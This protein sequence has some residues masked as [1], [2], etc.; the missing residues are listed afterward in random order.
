MKEYV[1]FRIPEKYAER[2]LSPDQGQ[3]LGDSVRKLTVAT[4][5]PLYE[6]IRIIEE[7]Q[8]KRGE[9]F[10][11]GWEI[12]HRYS[13]EELTAAQ[14][15][16]LAITAV[17]EP[18]GEECGTIYDE[19]TACK[20]CEAG[21][22]QKSS[23]TLDLR[24]A[25]KGKDL[26]R[27]IADEWIISQRLAEIFVNEKITGFELH[28][29]LHKTRYQDEPIDLKLVP[30][31][32]KIL[33]LAEDAGLSQTN[34]EF[35]VWLNRPELDEMMLRAE[36]EHAI[37]LERRD[38]KRKICLPIWYQCVVTSQ[39]IPTI[40]PTRFGIHPF[41]EDV[42]GRY[43]CP[44]GHVS[45]QSLLSEVFV[46]S[47]DYDGSDINITDDMVGIRRGLLVPSPLLLISPKLWQV[48]KA[49]DIK[50]YRIDV[51]HLI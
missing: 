19:S 13:A 4:N 24:K 18:T 38:I 10:F 9:F 30:T 20:I 15:F 26:A 17:F 42:E 35:Y 3:Q 51:A 45:G 21:R 46:L 36:E 41:D 47:S 12:K 32:R 7:Q 28:P 8:Q 39:P 2:F 50:G 29:V 44:L 37:L 14:L 49:N 16:S 22:K 34:W 27:T 31:G 40:S 25:P 43:R 11:L 1:E 5:D 33:D 6:R 23:L 48:L